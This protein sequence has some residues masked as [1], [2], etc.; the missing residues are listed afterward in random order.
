MTKLNNYIAKLLAV[1][2]IVLF[3]NINAQATDGYFSNGI[4]IQLKS[5]AGAG[6]AFKISPLGAA[7][8]PASLAFLNKGY[9]INLSMFNPNRDFEVVGNPTL[10][11]GTF[12][13]APGKVESGSSTF[14]IPAIAANWKLDE[15][16]S[17]GL[18]FYGNGGMNTTYESPVFGFD[19][20]G[21]NLIQMFLQPTF[22]IK[23]GEK[24]AFGISPLLAYQQFKADGLLAFRSFSG[25]PAALSDNG[26]SSS[27]G[28][29]AKFGYLGEL[30]EMISVG[31]SFQTPISMGKFEEYAGLYAEEGGFDIPMNWTAGVAFNLMLMEVAFDVKHIYY[32]DV[33]SI[34][35]PMIPN[36]MQG[37]LGSENGAGFG[38][39]D[40]TVYKVGLSYPV[41]E[42]WT[43]RAGYSF[44]DQP[45]QESEVMFNILAPGVVN[46]HF[47]FGVS[48]IIN[49]ENEL[50]FFVMRALSNS[51]KGANPL[52]VPGAQTIEIRMD[53]WEF[54]VGYSF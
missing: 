33:K 11:P 5:M 6:V 23:I 40:V 41:S 35:N 10:E 2:V 14:I 47:T 50:S 32:N 24:H 13:L 3:T 38:W 37:P 53:Q 44:G 19:P 39:E 21:V 20:T 45:I 18:A 27:F 48:K 34:G 36:L 28:I 12:G 1:A 42:A 15:N 16:K 30:H 8:N 52:D 25:N 54:G 26:N 31:F 22:A 29:G 4:G 46:Q 17:L 43:L 51:V 9:D 49:Y 7:T